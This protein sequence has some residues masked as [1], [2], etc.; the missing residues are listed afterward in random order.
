MTFM[1]MFFFPALQQQRRMYDVRRNNSQQG[2]P[3]MSRSRVQMI[4]SS[5]LRGDGSPLLV[6]R[7]QPA[8]GEGRRQVPCHGWRA[9]PLQAQ[10]GENIMRKTN[11]QTKQKTKKA[12][13]KWWLVSTTTASTTRW[14]YHQTTKTNINQKTFYQTKNNRQ[15]KTTQTKTTNNNI[16]KHP[17]RR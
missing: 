9:W 16:I 4:M 3:K 1:L 12:T 7:E 2:K 17:G 6:R 8:D 10:W 14:E 13:T 5:A 15:L 11:K